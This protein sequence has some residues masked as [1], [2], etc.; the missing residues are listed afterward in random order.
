MS[1]LLMQ[2]QSCTAMTGVAYAES[3]MGGPLTSPP[4]LGSDDPARWSQED[5]KDM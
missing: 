2:S 3:E 1:E 5:W 4:P